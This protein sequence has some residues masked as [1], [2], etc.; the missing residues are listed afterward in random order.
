MTLENDHFICEDVRRFGSRTCHLR[1]GL[2]ELAYD[3][4][5]RVC[6]YRGRRTVCAAHVP[7]QRQSWELCPRAV[8][9]YRGRSVGTLR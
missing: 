9:R 6:G 8:E 7:E 4:R 3:G 2:R 5:W 1:F